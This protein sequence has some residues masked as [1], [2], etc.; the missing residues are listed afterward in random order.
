MEKESGTDKHVGKL[1]RLVHR[2]RINGWEQSHGPQADK[3]GEKHSALMTLVNAATNVGT[4][5]FIAGACAAGPSPRSPL[6]GPP[7]RS[8]A[9]DGQTGAL[10]ARLMETKAWRS[11]LCE[12]LPYQVPAHNATLRIQAR[13]RVDQSGAASASDGCQS[14]ICRLF[15]DSLTKRGFVEPQPRHCPSIG[16]YSL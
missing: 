14:A 4:V 9:A 1:G 16:C 11:R 15:R 2:R 8:L 3:P 13:A 10:G 7:C 6:A 5:E 12:P